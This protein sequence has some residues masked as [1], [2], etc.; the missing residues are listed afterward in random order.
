MIFL[1]FGLVRF[2]SAQLASSLPFPLPSGPSPTA[3]V[4]LSCR[5]TLPSHRVKTSSLPLLYLPTRLHPVASPLE[6][7]LKH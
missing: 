3:D 1:F 2:V 4:I 6:P 7:K 5:V